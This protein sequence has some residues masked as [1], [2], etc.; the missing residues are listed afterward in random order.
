MRV[1]EQEKVC[2]G[3]GDKVSPR[4]GKRVTLPLLLRLEHGYNYKVKPRDSAVVQ[5]KSSCLGSMERRT[6]DGEE[7]FSWGILATM[8][9]TRPS[10]FS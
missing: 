7:G 4:T 5:L 3:P 6:L 8:K 10:C 1:S 2:G 9:E